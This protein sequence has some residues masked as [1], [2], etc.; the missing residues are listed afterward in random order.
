MA[1]TGAG[2]LAS[3]EASAEAS[4]AEAV[5]TEAAIPITDDAEQRRVHDRRVATWPVR[6]GAMLFGYMWFTQ[7]QWKLPWNGFKWPN[8]AMNGIQP[9]PNIAGEQLGPFIDNGH[10]LYHWMVQEAVHGN[11]ILPGFGSMIQNVVLPNWQ[12]FG[13]LTFFMESTIALTLILGLFS[14]LGGFLALAQGINLYF[15]LAKAPYEFDWSYGMMMGLGFIFMLTGA[16]RVWGLDQ[17][18]RPR[19]RRQIAAGNRLARLA[20]LLT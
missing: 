17:W 6:L 3:A 5:R 1:T 14:R 4:A 12:F 15:G 2:T 16:G 8:E 13:W 9:N 7:V 11:K 20:Y 18:L 10:G 19:L